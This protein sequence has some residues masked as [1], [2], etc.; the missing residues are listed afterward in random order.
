MIML[1]RS[2]ERIYN[3]SRYI[4]T[5]FEHICGEQLDDDFDYICIF[6][7]YSKPGELIS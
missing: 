5:M 3:P 2:S 1:T 4:G 6:R 7:G